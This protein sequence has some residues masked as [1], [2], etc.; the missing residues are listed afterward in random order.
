M[1]LVGYTATALSRNDIEDTPTNKNVVDFAVVELK[2]L[3]GNLVV[4]YD[5]AEGLNPEAQKTCDTNGQV[6]FFAEIGDYDL[7]I[8][9]KAQRI[10]LSSGLADFISTKTNESVQDFIDTFA[11]KIFQSPTDGGLTEIQT[12]TVNAGEVYE[13]RKTSDDSLS[14]IYSDAAGATEIV[15]DGASNVSDSDGVVE[16]YIADGDHYVEVDSIQSIFEVDVLRQDLANPNMGAAM[17]RFNPGYGSAEGRTVSS[18]ISESVST[19]DFGA[20]GDGVLHPVQEWI[21]SGR[22][23]SLSG[24]QAD[25]PFVT[26]LS[27]SIDWA[28]TQA[29]FNYIRDNKVDSAIWSGWQVFNRP[30][31]IEGKTN[32]GNVTRQLTV[33]ALIQAVGSG[34]DLIT[35]K[36][37]RIA[38]VSGNI[39]ILGAPLS[40]SP[41]TWKRGMVIEDSSRGKFGAQIT[42]RYFSEWGCDVVNIGNNVMLD[43]TYYRGLSCGTKLAMGYASKADSGGINQVNQRSLLTLDAANTISDTGDAIAIVNG[44]PHVITASTETTVTVYPWVDAETGSIEILKGGGFKIYGADGGQIHFGQFDAANCAIGCYL[45]PFY[46][47]SASKMTLEYNSVSIVADGSIDSI[48]L[49]SLL[50]NVYF[51]GSPIDYLSTSIAQQKSILIN[52]VAIRLD[53]FIQLAPVNDE[54]VPAVNF[55]GISTSI[56]EYDRYLV[57]QKNASNGTSGASTNIKLGTTKR[58]IR[59]NAHTVTLQDDVDVRRLWGYT[60][61]EFI[62]QGTGANDSILGTLTIN[63]E[64][65]YTING[66]ATY[67]IAA[68]NSKGAMAFH[69]RLIGTDWRLHRFDASVEAAETYSITNTVTK[70]TMDTDA[71]T[72]KEVADVLGTLISDLRARGIVL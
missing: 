6:T 51:E 30:L 33:N 17:V 2:D 43:F 72:T 35:F 42:C 61:I 1:N 56:L 15:Q 62:V 8:N 54:F 25:Y 60:D 19:Q 57:D 18:K 20:I 34:N 22:Y 64:T 49:N 44:R 41:R 67:S 13:V 50:S 11:L 71:T 68:P 53:K 28:A 32:N 27:D 31:I 3:Q 69:A 45:S 10:N 46:S 26:S 38:Q 29:F 40:T 4:M 7:E 14:T 21:D 66:G 24:I 16:F 48:T 55:Q 12:R 36:S 47:P 65:G 63:P 52:P 58:F 59:S 70:R 23:E 39:E 5:D 37:W 9:G